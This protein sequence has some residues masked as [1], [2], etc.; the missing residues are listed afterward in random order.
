MDIGSSPFPYGKQTIDDQDIDAVVS[1]LKSNYLT[2]G[3]L[4]EKFEKEICDYVGSRYCVVVNNGTAALHM[5]MLAAG[6]GSGDIVIVPSVTFAATANAAI[7]CGAEVVLADIDP[8]TGSMTVKCLEQAIEQNKNQRLKAVVL[9]HYAGNV[10]ELRQIRKLCEFHGLMLICDSCHALGSRFEGGVIGD[11]HEEFANSFSFHPVK[12]I[13]TCEGGAITTNNKNT[14]EVLRS[15]RSHSIEN[16]G[17][18]KPWSYEINKIGYNY[19][20][21]DVQCA[22]GISQLKRIE[23]F[24]EAREAIANRYSE[25]LEPLDGVVTPIKW[26]QNCRPSYHLY[27]VLIDFSKCKVT[28]S[29]LFVHAKSQGIGLQVHYIP[30]SAQ[31][32]YKRFDHVNDCSG[33][34]AFYEQVV[35]LPI[36]PELGLENIE[37]ITDTLCVALFQ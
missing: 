3:P 27:P 25:I 13:T 31:P 6:I 9:V 4:V 28:K 5:I 18:E 15:L 10:I 35:S 11:S 12:T 37:K 32:Y 34:L 17:V 8:S 30:L 20:L 24:I 2:T 16:R 21:P 22:L 14:Y 29:E 33:A 19:R 26:S 36:F 7:Y 23:S 1:A